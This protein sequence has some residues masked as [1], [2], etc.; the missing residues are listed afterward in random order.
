MQSRRRFMAFASVG[1]AALI[2]G[3]SAPADEGGPPETTTIRLQL[4]DVPP[5]YVNC[6]APLRLAKELLLAEGFADIRYV[7]NK[8][9][10]SRR[11]S[12]AVR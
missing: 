1:A 6:D 7:Y 2:G 3:T 11:R 4:E 10:R 5:R 12:R 9:L 8:V